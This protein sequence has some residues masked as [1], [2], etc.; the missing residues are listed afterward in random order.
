M[1][2]ER[3]YPFPYVHPGHTYEPAATRYPRQGV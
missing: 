2:N 1:P 3:W